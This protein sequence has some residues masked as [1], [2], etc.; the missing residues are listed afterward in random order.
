[1]RLGTTSYIYPADLLHNAKRLAEKIDDIELVIFES[2]TF[3]ENYPNKSEIKELCRIAQDH[4]LTY[5]VHLPLDL[6]LAEDRNSLDTALRVIDCT[7][8]LEPFGF[9][10]HL[11]GTALPGTPAMDRWLENS[12]ESL[13]AMIR[14]AGGAERLCVENLDDQSPDMLNCLYGLVPVSCCVDIGHLWKQDLDPVPYLDTWLAR[15]RVIHLHGVG[16]RDHKGLSL[17]GQQRLDPV[18]SLLADRFQGVLTFEVFNEP[19]FLD[20]QTTF[21]QALARVRSL[22]SETT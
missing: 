10:I 14:E 22:S 9:I 13:E 17:T 5:T 7:R 4:D 20:C 11:D 1:M 2:P 19:D 3:G 15:T 8:D 18:V 12:V 16:K 6:R 21:A